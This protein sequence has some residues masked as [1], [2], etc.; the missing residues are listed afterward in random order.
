M[1]PLLDGQYNE[2]E[3]EECKESAFLWWW[4]VLATVSTIVLALLFY[5]YVGQSKRSSAKYKSKKE[6]ESEHVSRSF[7]D[8]YSSR[9]GVESENNQTSVRLR[10]VVLN[11]SSSQQ[12]TDKHV[13]DS[14]NAQKGNFEGD[15]WS[16]HTSADQSDSWSKNSCPT[17]GSS[18]VRDQSD[19]GK[20][21]SLVSDH[22]QS[23]EWS[24]SSVNRNQSIALI[25]NCPTCGSSADH[26]HSDA[27]SKQ[28]STAGS[29]PDRNQTDGWSTFTAVTTNICPNCSAVDRNQS[30]ASSNHNNSD[31]WSTSLVDHD[32]SDAWT[33]HTTV[34]ADQ[35]MSDKHERSEVTLQR[36]K[37]LVNDQETNC[38]ND[39]GEKVVIT[40]A[41]GDKAVVS[42][43]S[44]DLSA[45][46]HDLDSLSS[47]SWET[48]RIIAHEKADGLSHGDGSS[49]HERKTPS[50]GKPMFVSELKVKS[51]ENDLNG[52]DESSEEETTNTMLEIAKVET[53]EELLLKVKTLEAITEI[54]RQAG[55]ESSNLIFGIDYTASNKY[56]GEESFSGRSLHAIEKGLV[57]PY[58]HVI[59]ILGKTLAPFASSGFIAAYGFGDVR[60]SDTDVFSF[61]PDSNCHS[62]DEVLDVYNKITPTVILSGPT[63]FAPLIYQAIKICKQVKDYHILV[64]VADGQVT[65]EKAT[66]RAI[67]EACRVPLSIIVVGVGD[68]PRI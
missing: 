68:G 12:S 10:K 54:M 14:P 50:P 44:N 4:R 1:D 32:Q 7:K 59:S 33:T 63:N 40:S 9:N 61:I 58:Q 25:K 27:W 43:R 65:N 47:D 8:D 45:T 28:T 62:F 34:P 55:L 51:T 41:S 16:K 57:N 24:T 35:H 15:A 64:I 23:D 11:T 20:K 22:N 21:S 48:I 66:T 17:C 2:N 46:S 6:E 36:Q 31:A 18:N 38:C 5:Y 49:F 37:N 53:T 42:R 3:W 52:E 13:K 19:A 56:Q 26:S 39:F 30:F 60:T 29:I 67:V